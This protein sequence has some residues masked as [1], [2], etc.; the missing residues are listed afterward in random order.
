M[1]SGTTR[2]AA[3]RFRRT[4]TAVLGTTAL[5]V[6][7]T[8]TTLGTAS[9]S[10]AQA[11]RTATSGTHTGR[12]ATERRLPPVVVDVR[13]TKDGVTRS[14]T[15]FRPGNTVF[16]IRS[17]GGRGTIEV[18]RLRHGYTVAHLR[19]DASTV[20]NG[21]VKA[22]RSIDRHVVFYGGSQLYPHRTA[23][24]ATYLNRGRYLVANLDKGIMTRMRVTGERQLR[25]LPHATG[26]I[27]LI[28]TDRFGNPGVRRHTGWMKSTN[29]TDEPH[30]IDLARV[31]ASTTRKQVKKY[32]DSG[33]QGQPKWALKAM[34]GTLVISP[35]HTVRWK[36]D[37]PRGKYLEMCWWP[38]DENGMPHAMMGMWALTHL[39]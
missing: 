26:R 15:N 14:R 9:A 1:T 32:F 7:L 36:Y 37:L 12:H 8:T 20:F 2:S 6:S 27:N 29:R 34:A 24:F 5:A 16:N 13:A 4:T 38:S 21:D 11:H 10:G 30:F 33:T 19:K 39:R 3:R 18:V 31:K 22:V 28:H 23:S 35:G 17:A 25:S